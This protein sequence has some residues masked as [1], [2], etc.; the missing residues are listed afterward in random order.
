MGRIQLNVDAESGKLESIDWAVIPV[1]S[2]VTEDPQFAPVTDKYRKLIVELAARVGYTDVPLDARDETNRTR[3]TN[4]G[5][6]IADAFRQETGADV[7]LIN[8][9]SIRADVI[10]NPGDLTKREVISILPFPNPVIKLEVTGKVLREALEHGVSR[11]AEDVQPG[12]F[13]QISGLRFSF[14]ARR[15]PGERVLEVKVN[16]QPLDDNKKYTLATTTFVGLDY[17]DGYYM[18]RGARLLILPEQAAKA[19]DIFMKAITSVKS[20][21]PKTDGRINRLD[22]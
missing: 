8:G 15:P 17:G 13:P 20:I 5:S 9:G 10:Y 12:R 11:S 1:T 22:Q 7:A 6:F 4:L 14:D 21:A 18:F 3:E 16:G 19:T 2:E